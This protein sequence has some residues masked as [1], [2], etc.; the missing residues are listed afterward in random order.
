VEDKMTSQEK[1]ERIAEI[2]KWA[3]DNLPLDTNKKQIYKLA[4]Q[5]LALDTPKEPPK[6]NQN[7]IDTIY[8]AIELLQGDLTSGWTSYEDTDKIIDHIL[9]LARILNE[10]IERGNAAP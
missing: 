10:V 4:D 7:L 1:R 3:L 2:L 5:I 8:L 9:T 6:H